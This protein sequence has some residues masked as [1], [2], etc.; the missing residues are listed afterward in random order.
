MVIFRDFTQTKTH[1]ASRAGGWACS[2]TKLSRDGSGQL[3]ADTEQGVVATSNLPDDDMMFIHARA[4]VRAIKPGAAEERAR[5]FSRERSDATC[6]LAWHVLRRRCAALPP[7]GKP[8]L[9]ETHATAVGVDD[10]CFGVVFSTLPSRSPNHSKTHQNHPYRMDQALFLTREIATNSATLRV[11]PVL[12]PWPCFLVGELSPKRRP[13]RSDRREFTKDLRSVSVRVSDPSWPD[14]PGRSKDPVPRRWRDG[15]SET[16]G[17]LGE[18]SEES[19]DS[20]IRAA[21]RGLLVFSTQRDP[22]RE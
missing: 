18:K 22:T 7:W 13:G 11:P 6:F 17:G 2:A 4:I 21:R 15:T 12:L 8:M 16:W 3:G 9:G 20:G 1:H 10:G 5:F 19:T 14:P